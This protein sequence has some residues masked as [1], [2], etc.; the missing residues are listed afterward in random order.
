MTAVTVHSDFGVWENKV[1]YCFHFF[2]IYLPWSDGPDIIILY[3]E[4]WVISQLFRSPLSLSSRVSLVPLHFLLLGWCHLHI[5]GYWYFS[6]KSWFQLKLHQAQH[7]TWC[8]LHRSYIS[9]VTVYSLDVCCSMSSSNCCF[10]TCIHVSQEAGNAVCP[11]AKL[12][13]R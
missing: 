6:W 7:F 5:W 11:E 2:P 10:L 12:W 13:Q 3:F 4:C 8:T 9:R 1:C